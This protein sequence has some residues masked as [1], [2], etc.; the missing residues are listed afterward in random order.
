MPD[1]LSLIETCFSGLVPAIQITDLLFFFFFGFFGSLIVS[2]LRVGLVVMH[3]DSKR[4]NGLPTPSLIGAGPVRHSWLCIAATRHIARYTYLESTL[5]TYVMVVNQYIRVYQV[6]ALK[7]P[8]TQSNCA[9][10]AYFRARKTR[11]KLNHGRAAASRLVLP[12]CAFHP[13]P[14]SL[15]IPSYSYSLS[16]LPSLTSS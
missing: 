5:Q 14:P 12:L 11:P 13:L 7:V 8:A 3:D 1:N 4:R 6:E 15:V 9:P 16:S 2:R 10:E